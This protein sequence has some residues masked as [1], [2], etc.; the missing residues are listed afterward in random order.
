MSQAVQLADAPTPAADETTP[1]IRARARSEMD[2]HGLS[3]MA[4]AREM[5]T[6]AATLGRW[7]ADTYEGDVARVTAKVQR[8]LETRAETRRLTLTPAGLDSHTALAVTDDV[9]ATLAHA[10]ATGDIVLVHGRSGA[11]KSWAA[12]R[13]VA[14]RAGAHAL[15]ISAGIASLPGLYGRVARAVG[16]GGRHGSALE[17]EDAI[18]AR[19]EG[20]QALLVIDEAQHLNARLLDALRGLRDLSGAGLALIGDDTIRMT[21]ARCPQVTGRIG[22]RTALGAPPEIDVRTLM[23]GVLGREPTRAEIT[24]GLTTAAGPGGLHALRRL[25][26]RAW[27]IA[28]AE[29]RERINPADIAA[30]TEDA[31]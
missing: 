3:Q 19:L 6:S 17:T 10:Q 18:L 26:A 5:G 23:A 2:D 4:A 9:M 14:G 13:Y 29:T 8:W 15:T 16:A 11:G 25:M 22:V 7:L 30:A 20:R 1:A 27:M 31:A 28:R 12:A 21:L 24:M